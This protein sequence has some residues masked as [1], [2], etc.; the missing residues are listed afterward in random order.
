MGEGQNNTHW[1]TS[2]GGWAASIGLVL[3]V[4][5]NA[6]G[7]GDSSFGSA[8]C[9]FGIFGL[10]A[11]GIVSSSGAA[12]S[13]DGTMVLKQ[14]NTG[15][16]NWVQ[17]QV[18]GDTTGAAS[19]F[20]DE[21]TQIM[22]R[23]I[24][25]VRGGKQLQDLPSNELDILASA[26]GV[27]SGSSQQKIEALHNSSLAKNALKLGALGVAGGAG[28]I[29][30]AQ[31]IKS[32]RQKAMD[33]AE[34]LREQGREKIKENI[35]AGKYSINAKLPTNESGDRA[36]DVAGNIILDQLKTQIE[37]RNLTPE[38]MLMLGDMNKDGKLDS[39]EIAGALT[40][41]TGF[42]VPAFIVSDAMKDF[43]LNEDGKLDLNEMNVLWTKLGFEVDDNTQYSDDEIDAVLDE[44][45]E[46]AVNE[47]EPVVDDEL[48]IQENSVETAAEPSTDIEL[49]QE[50]EVAN[51][52]TTGA[53]IIPQSSSIQNTGELSEEIDTEFE[54]LVVE[55]ESA[56]FSSE[57]K[58]LMEKQTSEFLV[59]I[60][61]AKM[62][63]TLVGDSKYRGGQSVHGLLDGGP[64]TGVVK[65]PV[66]LDDKI[67]SF[68]EG[69]VIQLWASLVDFSPS[70][71][72]PVL[73]SSEIV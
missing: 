37:S 31:I 32:S 52:E 56:R 9:C 39:N 41:A 62:E 13:S 68:K 3:I 40:A 73:E 2:A 44:V 35:E 23:V 29:G 14:D 17:N 5:E 12:V 69:D 43:D 25:E 49:E 66:E 11:G 22:S 30:A 63:R 1:L 60:K 70:L 21:N 45:G 20:N 15:Q 4:I 64:Y 8:C 6:I 71:K 67:L 7:A 51:Q 28:A 34:E 16:W 27:E 47:D 50:D 24:S 54:R 55:M 10:I 53:E 57:R 48:T 26:Y 18:Q 42:S 38:K 33:R 19:H 46:E 65:V 59:T 58:A 36:T 61:I 72:R